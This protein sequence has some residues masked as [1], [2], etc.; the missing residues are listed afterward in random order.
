MKRVAAALA[1][2]LLALTAPAIAQDAYPSRPI[3]LIVPF[4]PGGSTDAIGRIV[5]EG[6][7][8]ALGQTVVV[9]NRAGAGGSMGTAAIAQAEPDGY[10]IGIGTASTLAINPA[11][12]RNLSFD[13]LTD[14]VPIGGIAEVPNIMS[15]NP[16]VQATDMAAFIALARAHPGEFSYASAGNGSVSHL[17][18]EQFKL[19]TGTDLVHVPYKGVGPALIDA[20]GGQVEVMYDNLPT[21]LPLVHEGRL[22]ALA[23]SGAARLPALPDVPTF[24]EAGLEDMNWMAFF[25]LVA[26]KGTP[27]PIVRRLSE[28]L[29]QAL[30]SPDV[31]DK[32][33]AQQAVV[34]ASSPAEFMAEIEREL[35][36]MQDAAA[37]ASIRLE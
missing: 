9:E 16:S 36:R 19:A 18:G 10:T 7:R 22:R 17:L 11:V 26:P 5:A 4:A 30:A 6:L 33:V 2:G 31:R 27:E 8:Q 23:V 25:G 21:S 3:T 32:L 28:A 37:A 34:A 1:F 35:K 15:V 13:V 12:Y 14:L 20:V 24:A 29:G